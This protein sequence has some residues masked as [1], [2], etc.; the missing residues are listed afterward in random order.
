MEDPT[1]P[2]MDD[3]WADAME[4][5]RKAYEPK[6]LALLGQIRQACL[7]EGIPVP[8][9]PFPMCDDQ[10]LWELET[11]TEHQR[12]GGE[13]GVE[14]E[15]VTEREYDGGSGYGMNFR[16]AVIQTGGVVFAD[17]QPF[18]YTEDVWVDAREFA[19]V[20]QRW[21]ALAD[22]KMGMITEPLRQALASAPRW[23]V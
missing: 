12:Q 23:T 22:L 11:G 15:V 2:V 14:I 21:Q 3:G 7:D 17:Y 16:L 4:A 18:N 8:N 20:A 5:V 9:S 13:A 1:S 6:V 19:A 10:I